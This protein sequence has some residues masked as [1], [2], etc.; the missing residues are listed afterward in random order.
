MQ[1]VSIDEFVR[2]PNRYKGVVVVSG[3]VKKSIPSKSFFILG[4]DDDGDAMMPVEYNKQLPKP[5]TKITV[6]GELAET[7]EGK[8]IFKATDIENEE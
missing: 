1:V 3:T 4:C 7:K 6:I 5:E 8:Y 2:Q